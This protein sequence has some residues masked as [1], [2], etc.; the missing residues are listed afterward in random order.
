MP[1]DMGA[2]HQF[3]LGG[4]FLAWM[5]SSEGLIACKAGNETLNKAGS[6]EPVCFAAQTSVPRSFGWNREGGDCEGFKLRCFEG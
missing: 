4:R 3:Q 1:P 5:C 2:G 6:S